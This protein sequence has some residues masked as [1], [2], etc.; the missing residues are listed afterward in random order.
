[1][2]DASIQEVTFTTSTESA[3]MQNGGLRIN[4]TPKDGSNAF[5]GTVFAYGMNG[6]LQADNRSDEVKAAGVPQ[7]SI[8]YTYEINPSVGGPIRRDK[9]WFYFTYKLTDTASFVTLPDQSQGDEAV[10]Q[11]Q[12]RDPAHVAG[13]QPRQVPHL[14]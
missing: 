6:G 13:H 12:L 11:R 3:E 4:S 5:T 7:P 10:A 9:L 1:M 14:R 8:D 2:N